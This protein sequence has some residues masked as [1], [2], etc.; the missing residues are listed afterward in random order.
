MET[1]TAKFFVRRATPADADTMQF[2]W[3]ETSD[4]LAKNDSRFRAAENA[5]AGWG[6]SLLEWM[7]RDDIAIFVAESKITEGRVLG[8]IIGSVVTNVPGLP[9]EHHGYVTELAV[10]SHSKAG[11]IGRAL[12][13]DLRKWFAEH[14]VTHVE[15]RVPVRH[16]I[17]Q[18]FW[19]A[20]G[21]SEL[22]EQMWLKLE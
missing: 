13:D 19:R 20:L 6:K 16:A 12:F 8:Y 15:A 18:A 22:Y 10:D 4:T 21:A 14:G 9:V 17:A 5:A 1:N 3:Q 11:G 2:I 7:K